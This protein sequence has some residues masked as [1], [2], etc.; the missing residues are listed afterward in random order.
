MGSRVFAIFIVANLNIKL[1]RIKNNRL[2]H[3]RDK[4]D[5]N[6]IDFVNMEKKTSSFA[7]ICPSICAICK[8]EKVITVAN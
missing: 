6:T 2:M 3:Q 1:G 5:E 4:Y 7:A 8:I